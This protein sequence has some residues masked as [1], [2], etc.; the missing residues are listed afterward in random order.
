MIFQIFLIS[1]TYI[2]GYFD[3]IEPSSGTPGALNNAIRENLR[4]YNGL[5]GAMRFLRDNGFDQIGNIQ[6]LREILDRC[7][8]DNRQY[9]KRMLDE[10]RHN[11]INELR[12]EMIE[13][14]GKL[15]YVMK[16][17]K[18][19]ESVLQKR[20]CIN[21]RYS[22]G[23]NHLPGYLRDLIWELDGKPQRNDPGYYRTWEHIYEK[24]GTFNNHLFWATI[25]HYVRTSQI[26]WSD[27]MSIV[28]R[29]EQLREDHF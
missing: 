7:P 8:Y 2:S 27:I 5:I 22:H 13:D 24:I 9:L 16:T 3:P 28:E 12:D 1:S 21:D 14:C 26:Y 18:G 15:Y 19:L 10:G 4:I 17:C 29:L 11:T 23:D 25:A 6:D 20:C